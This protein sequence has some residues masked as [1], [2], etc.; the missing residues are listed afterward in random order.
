MKSTKML[1]ILVLALALGLMLWSGRLSAAEPMGKGFTY[2]GHLYDSNNVANGLYDFEF[3]LYDDPCTGSQVGSDVNKPDVDVIDA[4]FTVELDFGSS[5]FDGNAVWLEIGVRPGDLNDPNTYTTLSPRQEI[6][7]TPYALYAETSWRQ[8]VARRVSTYVVAASD[9]KW[10][11]DADYICDGTEDDVQIQAAIDALPATGGSVHLME[12]TFNVAASITLPSY[13]TLT[14]S[15]FSTVLAATNTCEEMILASEENYICISDLVLDGTNQKEAGAWR[16]ISLASVGFAIIN[17]VYI[18]DTDHDGIRLQTSNRIEISNVFIKSVGGHSILIGYGSQYVTV[19]NYFSDSPHLEHVCIE[20]EG[21]GS[22][23]NHHITLNNIIGINAGNAGFY[24]QHAHTVVFNNC[25]SEGSVQPEFII[26]DCV[27]VCLN[28]CIAKNAGSYG[29]FTNDNVTEMVFNNCQVLGG[30]PAAAFS[31]GSDRTLLTGC[32]ENVGGNGYG[33]SVSGSNVLITN[34]QF[35]HHGG[36]NGNLI[37]VSNC[38]FGERDSHV[39]V[40]IKNGATNIDFSNCLF[41]GHVYIYDVSQDIRFDHCRWH[42]LD[43]GAYGSVYIAPGSSSDIVITN[44][45]LKSGILGYI[46]DNAGAAIIRDNTGY[47][48]ENW[49]S[50]QGTG[51][52][53]TIVHGLS[54]VPTIVIISG[55]SSDV[56]AFQSSAADT[57]NIYITADIG[58]NYHWEAKVR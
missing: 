1:T 18:Q 3:K 13:T 27:D 7:P 12:G 29:F 34:S 42:D 58:E 37:Q 20:W 11:S 51:S 32:I 45:V 49:G 23:Q 46:S 8:G 43:G 14:G 48:T 39:S 38:D 25:I 35:K 53:Q 57:M 44:N 36:F 2:Q 19:T 55:D 31:I 16:G 30:V 15:G 52:Q 5:V 40:Y 21:A 54:A 24:I 33:V 41:K 28:N 56:N 50:S 17:N 22:A 47:V 6:T 4:Y 9:S 26:L 10:K